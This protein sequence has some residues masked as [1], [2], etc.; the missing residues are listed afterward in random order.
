[1]PSFSSTERINAFKVKHP[2]L[3]RFGSAALLSVYGGLWFLMA[4][5]VA[6][7]MMVIFA[8]AGFI[9]PGHMVRHIELEQAYT[10]AAPFLVLALY[11]MA[12]WEFRKAVWHL[13]TF[14]GMTWAAYIL[15]EGMARQ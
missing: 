11:R 7:V 5:V 15:I 10:L 8:G 6:I 12:Q 1:M 9:I 13:V 2:V 14:S 4:P 3:A